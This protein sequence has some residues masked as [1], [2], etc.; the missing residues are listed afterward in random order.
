L[1][2]S[3]RRGVVADREDASR[4]RAFNAPCSNAP[5]HC[6]I[7]QAAFANAARQGGAALKS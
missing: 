7:L 4:I 6:S 5:V 1:H 3:V 2:Q